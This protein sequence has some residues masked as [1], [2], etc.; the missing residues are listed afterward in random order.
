VEMTPCD[1]DRGRITFRHRDGPPRA[2]GSGPRP[3]Y[4]KR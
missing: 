3:V 2:P 4:R 1:L